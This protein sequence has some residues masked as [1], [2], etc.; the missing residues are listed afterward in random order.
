MSLMPPLGSRQCVKLYLP[1]F[2]ELDLLV[3]FDQTNSA[4]QCVKLVIEEQLAQQVS[5]DKDERN[6]VK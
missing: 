3:Q 1:N 5:R 4:C 6:G 2:V